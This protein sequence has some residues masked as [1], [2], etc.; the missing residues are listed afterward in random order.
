LNYN[1]MEIKRVAY[2][3]LLMISF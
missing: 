1:P 3:F 2:I